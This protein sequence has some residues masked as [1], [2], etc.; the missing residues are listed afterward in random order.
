MVAGW[1]VGANR[2]AAPQIRAGGAGGAGDM[3]FFVLFSAV[4]RR[5]RQA[6]PS[7][8]AFVGGPGR[9]IQWRRH[10]PNSAATSADWPVPQSSTTTHLLET[11]HVKTNQE[12]DF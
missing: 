9:S 8:L 11:T 5:A 1:P 6:Q 3:S 4:S 12:H 10:L 7:L 2:G